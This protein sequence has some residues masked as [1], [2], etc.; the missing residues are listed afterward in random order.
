MSNIRKTPHTSHISIQNNPYAL[1]TGLVDPDVGEPKDK[2]AS[3]GPPP[4]EPHNNY[5]SPLN[6]AAL[7]GTEERFLSDRMVAE[8]YGVQKQTIWRWA[9]TS[10]LFPK[11]IKFEG[12]TT[13]WRL[14][15]L[16]AYE[17]QVM[18]DKR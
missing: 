17:R 6:A 3:N 15:D 14:S 7:C 1:A 16:I 2:A 5:V 10:P 13:R 8:R 9:K 11:P 18:G 12:G 4:T